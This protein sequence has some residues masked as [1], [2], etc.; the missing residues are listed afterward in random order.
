MSTVKYRRHIVN[1]A[2]MSIRFVSRGCNWIFRMINIRVPIN[3]I[4]F[5]NLYPPHASKSKMYQGICKMDD[6]LDSNWTYIETF[7]DIL[8]IP[9]YYE[10]KVVIVLRLLSPATKGSSTLYPTF[11]HLMLIRREQEIGT[12]TSIKPKKKCATI[13]F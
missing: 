10:V 7:A 4:S 3:C 13:R 9:F 8:F 5:G 12:Y 2:F 1:F 6:V 11:V